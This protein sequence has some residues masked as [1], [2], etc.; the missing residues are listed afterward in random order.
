MKKVILSRALIALI[1]VF[2]LLLSYRIIDQNR[3][4]HIQETL[5]RYSVAGG[6]VQLYRRSDCSI[7]GRTK[8]HGN[9]RQ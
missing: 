5:F 7:P 2:I 1:I 8:G 4:K 6:A 9:S 3:L